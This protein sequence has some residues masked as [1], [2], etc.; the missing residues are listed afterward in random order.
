M[1]AA[2]VPTETEKAQISVNDSNGLSQTAI[3]RLIRRHRTTISRYSRTK[4][5]VKK[6]APRRKYK[7]LSNYVVR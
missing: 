1:P 6:V 4:V 5:T 3:G 2:K 7:K